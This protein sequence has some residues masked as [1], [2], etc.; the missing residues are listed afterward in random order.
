MGRT[1][2]YSLQNGTIAVS[3][4]KNFKSSLPD[5]YSIRISGT[6]TFNNGKT[7]EVDIVLD[8][9]KAIMA[10]EL[11]VPAAFKTKPTEPKVTPITA[12]EIK[13]QYTPDELKKI[14]V[15]D[16]IKK[17]FDLYKQGALTK[18]EYE[19]QKKKLLDRQ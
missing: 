4:L 7:G 1:D 17:L 19:A 5:N 6:A 13:N 16:E 9:E 2:S 14:L 18:D 3:K 8:F 11:S 15:A 10:G 12:A